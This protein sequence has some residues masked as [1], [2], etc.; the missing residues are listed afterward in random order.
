MSHGTWTVRMWAPGWAF[1]LIVGLAGCREFGA[2][3]NDATDAG[4]LADDARAT[5]DRATGPDGAPEAAGPRSGSE[6]PNERDATPAGST[7]G[8]QFLDAGN[9]SPPSA[10]PPAFGELG[11]LCAAAAEC[12]SGHCVDGVCCESACSGSCE[13]CGEAN[14]K[15]RCVAVA[16]K[17]RQGHPACT[18][19]SGSGAGGGAG[20]DGPCAG[21]CDGVNR[22]VCTYP[23]ASQSCRPGSC[24]ANVATLSASCDGKGACPASQTVDCAPN[25]CAGAICAGGCTDTQPCTGA[26]TCLAGKC[27]PKKTNGQTCQTAGE[28]NSGFCADGTCCDS[29]CTGSCT[30]CNLAGTAGTCSPVKSGID[31]SCNGARTCDAQGACKKSNGQACATAADCSSG[32]CVDGFCCSVPS[33]GA[34]QACTAGGGTCAKITGA[35]DADS[36]NTTKACDAGGTCKL[37]QGQACTAGSQ[38]TSGFCADGV[39]CNSACGGACEACAE[40]S[41]KGTCVAVTGAPRSGHA[42]CAGA[43]TTCGGTCD[44]MNRGACVYPTSSCRGASCT[45]GTA[46]VA[47]SCDGKGACPAM[48]TVSCAPNTCSGATC[49]GGCSSSQPCASTS[50][51]NAGVCMAKKPNGS[52]CGAAAECTNGSCADGVC[53]GSAC[54]ACQACTGANGTCV[55]VKNADDPDSC[56]GAST[57]D[58]A[59]ACLKKQ[60]QSCTSPAQCITGQCADGVCC[61]K[62]CTGSC[63]YCGGNSATNTAAGTC[64]NISGA[65]RAG[66]PA[67]SGTGACQGTC[68]GSQ[69]ACKMPG[70]ATMCRPASCSA[71]NA[72]EAAFC[73]GTGTCPSSLITGCSPEQSC[74]SNAQCGCDGYT[75]PSSCGGCGSWNF[76]NGTD[77]QRWFVPHPAGLHNHGVLALVD[78]SFAHKGSGSLALEF[79]GDAGVVTYAWAA[80]QVCGSSQ[81]LSG[82]GYSASVWV[83]LAANAAATSSHVVGIGLS[84]GSATGIGGTKI[85]PNAWTQVNASLSGQQGTSVVVVYSGGAL[86]GTLYIDEV[87]L[88]GP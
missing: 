84:A 5:V 80:A 76:E 77:P 11:A 34:C 1:T 36:C 85:T 58:G 15:G 24:T 6:V 8:G 66:H 75:L 42:A 79:T 16:G 86:T 53:C 32:A 14:A 57:C 65:P 7:D 83:Y 47:A 3:P 50:Y 43:G 54:G 62:A 46:T 30:A 37:K 55:A 45:N 40:A 61:N 49:A 21:V 71:D 33:C 27:V 51:C 10:N 88:T 72:A 2:K 67:C 31:D 69:S 17:P 18:G 28:C 74:K 60:G 63:E 23:G 13:A 64:G 20:S 44:G 35:E 26:N 73:N 82:T 70:S 4:T 81:A 87:T 25:A 48:Q 12:G 68:D 78:E 39:C 38:C 56:T 19:G 59:G 41:S 22:S 9:D 52:A 29:A